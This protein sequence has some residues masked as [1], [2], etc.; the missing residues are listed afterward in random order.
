M[1]AVRDDGGAV[2]EDMLD[3]AAVVERVFEGRAVFKVL[4][5]EDDEVGKVALPDETAVFQLEAGGGHAGHLADGLLQPQSVLLSD[6]L[7]EVVDHAGEVEG[8]ARAL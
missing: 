2:D 5:V 6:V 8:M 1:L 4:V 3:A 7:G